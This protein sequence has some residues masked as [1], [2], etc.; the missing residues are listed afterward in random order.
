MR[1]PG[2]GICKFSTAL[3]AL[4]LLSV[5]VVGLIYVP[6]VSNY[7]TVSATG[8]PGYDF[9]VSDRSKLKALLDTPMHSFSL[10]YVNQIVFETLVHS[11]SRRVLPQENWLLWA[12][13]VFYEPLGRTQLPSRIVAGGGG[14]CNELSA[15]VNEVAMINGLQTRFIGLSG[16]VVAEVKTAD[17]WQ[18]ADPDYG[19]VYPHGLKEMEKADMTPLIVNELAGKGYTPWKIDK[20]LTI[21]QSADDNTTQSVNTAISPRLYAAELLAEWLKWIIPMVL[22]AGI[23]YFRH[24]RFS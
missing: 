14:L 11:D 3:L 24:N 1:F 13:G 9:A 2:I 20:Y 17:G 19:V 12:A 6:P 4:G 15:V 23:Y 8:I 22:L 7:A 10:E 18:I 21:L 5:N 16:H